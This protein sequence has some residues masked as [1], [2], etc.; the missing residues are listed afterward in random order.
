MNKYIALFGAVQATKI[1]TLAQLESQFIPDPVT[2][3]MTN[4]N[5]HADFMDLA[6]YFGIKESPNS[7]WLHQTNSEKFTLWTFLNFVSDRLNIIKRDIGIDGQDVIPNISS[8]ISTKKEAIEAAV[9]TARLELQGARG[10][11]LEHLVYF[12]KQ[13]EINQTDML[14]EMVDRLRFLTD[15]LELIEEALGGE[16]LYGT[17][18]NT[19]SYGA[20]STGL[21]AE[22]H[23]EADV[24]EE[25]SNNDYIA[26]Y[27]FKVVYHKDN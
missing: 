12:V 11:N 15:R 6:L 14:H 8:Q 13:S 22:P 4:D 9:E 18:T 23:V 27:N 19:E 20:Y 7:S 2:G 5:V 3:V 26:P 21:I 10:Y 16:Y 24:V 17:G 25:Y 1:N